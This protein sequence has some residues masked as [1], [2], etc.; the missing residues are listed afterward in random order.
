M[1]EITIST[2]SHLARLEHEV[3]ILL[4]WKKYDG[5]QAKADGGFPNVETVDL[6]KESLLDFV[7]QWCV[8][9]AREQ[10]ETELTIAY[11]WADE[12]FAREVSITRLSGQIS[13]LSDGTVDV[14]RFR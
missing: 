9:F 10:E 11:P 7:A 2:L 1:L 8:R 14:T 5:T 6:R 12:V 4:E 13:G 3:E